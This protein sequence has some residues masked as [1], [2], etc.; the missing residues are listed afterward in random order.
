MQGSTSVFLDANF[1]LSE[2]QAIDDASRRMAEELVSRLAEGWGSSAF[3][4][5]NQPLGPDT[6]APAPRNLLPAALRSGSVDG[7]IARELGW[8]LERLAA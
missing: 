3:P 2:R 8:V 7:D 4:E 6:S 1:Q 5:K